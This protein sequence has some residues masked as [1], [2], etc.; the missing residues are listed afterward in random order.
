MK[1]QRSSRFFAR[2][3]VATLLSMTGASAWAGNLFSGPIN[4]PAGRY[5][6]ALAAGDFNG[7]GKLDLAVTNN[8]TLGVLGRVKV[9]L[10]EGSGVFQP[11]VGYRVGVG[12]DSVATGDFNGDGKQD[13]V[14][15]NEREPHGSG[16]LSVLL[17]NGDGTFQ[18]QVKYGNG[19]RQPPVRVAVGDFNGDGKLDLAVANIAVRGKRGFVGILLGNGDGTFQAAIQNPASKSPA[20]IAVG[21]LNG[22]GRLDLVLADECAIDCTTFATTAL[23]GNGDGTFQV[24]WTSKI[25]FTPGALALGDFNGDGK[26]DLAETDSSG[27]LGIRLGNGDGT[28]QERVNYPAGNGPDLI[29]VA[30]F[31][32]DG[33][34]DVAVTNRGS[35]GSVSV[36]LGKGDGTFQPPSNYP[37]NLVAE[38]IEMVAVDVNGDKR[39]DLV[40][41]DYFNKVV[42]VLLNTGHK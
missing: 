26:L 28:F 30:D 39:P 12:P 40:V 29:A 27:Q 9:L 36:L 38:P 21:D 1:H 8:N 19:G 34:L 35:S 31:D 4:S 42:S 10:G 3:V 16:R 37:L 14:V 11:P 23:L 25:K 32:G 22:D 18:P 2:L 13:L 15:V 33:K 5:P 24:T 41:T 7:D 6:W 17:G 20:Y